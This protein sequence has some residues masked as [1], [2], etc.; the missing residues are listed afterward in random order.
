MKF[1]ITGKPGSGKTTAVSK[2]V[3]LLLQENLRVRGIYTVEKIEDGKRIGF[4]VVG[5]SDKQVGILA[6]VDSESP[7]RVGKYGVDLGEFEKLCEREFEED[8]DI[9]VIDEVGPMEL[10]S[11][12]F[13]GVVKS[14]LSCVKPALFTVHQKSQAGTVLDVKNSSELYTLSENNREE[15]VRIIA[16]KL[17]DSVPKKNT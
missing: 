14:V 13:K 10:K 1:A 15:V 9:F 12:K 5:I 2:V 11:A 3:S 6:R 16:S 4:D 17:L 8:F 7:L